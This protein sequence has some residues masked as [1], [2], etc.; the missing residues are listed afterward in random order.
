MSPQLL[1]RRSN[2]SVL[3]GALGV[4]SAY[5]ATKWWVRR[6]VTASG[7]HLLGPLWLRLT[8]NSG[9]SFSFS[10]ATPLVTSLVTLALVLALAGVAVRATNGL[11]TVGFGLLVGGGAGN[12]LDRLT[13]LPHRVTDFLA[14]GWFPVFNVAD[15]AV[16]LGVASL[17]LA[18]LRGQRLVQR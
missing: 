18:L 5:S 17:V 9:I 15:A 1:D 13:H 6:H 4:V 8:Y 10:A 14:L 7:R 12:A 3:V 11:A 16:S 2:V